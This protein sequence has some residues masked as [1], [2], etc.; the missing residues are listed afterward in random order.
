MN[1]IVK[2]SWQNVVVTG[3]DRV[4]GTKEKTP[5]TTQTRVENR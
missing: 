4:S 5:H 2:S 1:G 3:V